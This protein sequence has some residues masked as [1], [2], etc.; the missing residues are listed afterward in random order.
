MSRQPVDRKEVEDLGHRVVCQICKRAGGT[1]VKSE[2][3]KLEV[4]DLDHLDGYIH[5][6]CQ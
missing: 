6:H 4:E 3:K 1:L 5:P 2:N